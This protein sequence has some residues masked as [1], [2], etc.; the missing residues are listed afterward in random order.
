MRFL[1]CVLALLLC[2][3]D[4]VAAG[5]IKSGQEPAELTIRAA[6]AH[7]VRVSLIPLS[8]LGQDYPTPAL[9]EHAAGEPRLQLRELDDIAR[10]EVGDLRLEVRNDPLRVTVSAADGRAIQELTFQK[11]SEVAFRLDDQPVLGLGEG[12]PAP[13][14]N[15]REEPIEFDR[16]GRKFEMRPR[17]QANA[18]GSRNPVP[19]LLGTAGW[20]LLVA[21]P[22]V[23]VDLAA[24][25]R[26][27]FQAW[28][29]PPV[30]ENA[31]RRGRAARTAQRQGRPPESSLTPG[32]WD[33]LIF[34]AKDP[35]WVMQDVSK[36]TGPAVLPPKWALGYMQSHRTLEDEDQMLRIVDTFR[37]K[38]IPLDAVIYLGTGF[39]PRGW[40]L[41]QPSFDFNPEV[42]RR[43]PRAV[44][45]DL[46]ERNVRV[47]VHVVPYER[48]RLPTLQGSIPAQ[49]GEELDA[50]HI[51]NYWQLHSGMIA[52]G[53]DAFWP[54]E[55]DWFD[56]FERMKRHELYYTGPLSSRPDVRPWS[57]HRNGYL[58]VARWGGWVWS[59]DTESSWKTLEG[60]VAV[61]INHSLSLSPYWG[62]DIGGFYPNP[63]LTGELY[64]R[65]F[66]FGAFCPSFRSHG[67]TWWTRLPWGWGLSEM[68]PLENG[69]SN[70]LPSELNNAAIEPV[71]RKYAQLRSQLM[72]YTYTLAREA[73]DTGLPFMRAMW[74]HYPTDAEARRRGDQYLWG[75][76]LLVAPVFT[77]GATTRDVYLPSGAWYDWWTNAPQEGG[78]TV[79]REVDLETMPLYVRA[80]AII[81][82]DPV[83]QYVSE[84]AD[85]PMTLRI[86]AGADGQD[87]LYEDD[88]ISQQYLEGAGTWTQFTWDDA[89]RK[90]TISP[91]ERSQR[92]D[93]TSRKFRVQLLPSGETRTV[94]YVGKPVVV[95]FP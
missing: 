19:M 35:A 92:V 43:A 81:P 86:Y 13:Q 20:G 18:Y 26:G 46:H 80:G 71:C 82:F 7:G 73:R 85:E 61:G 37:E 11:A 55:G 8:R 30:A 74:L 47:I 4:F 76:D 56:L 78:R 48:E 25:D 77:K 17:W 23:S 84:P 15:W 91:D 44:M 32:L 42:F 33:V 31:G 89:Q 38:Q 28:E 88:G 53:I 51:R 22:W 14:G 21:S 65:W 70:P 2:W 16:R 59:G 10:V 39:C 12:G 62:S 95:S 54:D 72:P 57:L 67:R 34:D 29:P 24:A 87:T 90:L 5:E 52:A 50:S 64:A 49:P 41:T 68:G 66:Q 40:N 79:Q 75:R 27:T 3:A 94:D 63:E 58:G 9:V 36:L 83:R 60:Q 45:D 1:T 93:G 69:R 6:G